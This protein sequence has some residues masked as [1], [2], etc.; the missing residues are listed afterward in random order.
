MLNMF[1]AKFD[2]IDVGPTFPP[3]L[4]MVAPTPYNTTIEPN[5]TFTLMLVDK[6]RHKTKNQCVPKRKSLLLEV[7]IDNNN[8]SSLN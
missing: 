2:I 8:R 7:C 6:K 1:K 4:D 5:T 3:S